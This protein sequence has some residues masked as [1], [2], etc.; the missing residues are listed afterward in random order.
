MFRILQNVPVF[1]D[2]SQILKMFMFSFSGVSNNVP[3]SKFV[4][5]CVK[6]RVF[7]FCLLFLKL[8]G[9]LLFKIFT[10]FQNFYWNFKKM[11]PNPQIVPFFKCSC[12][13]FFSGVSIFLC[14]QFWSQVSRNVCVS[15]FCFGIK[16]MFLFEKKYSR[17]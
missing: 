6:R 17:F 5:K 8:F 11:F 1:R 13:N 4:W 16:K 9:M 12:F 7:K 3:I 14:Y 10:T 2:C 15:I